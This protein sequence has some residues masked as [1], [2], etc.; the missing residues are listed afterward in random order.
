MLKVTLVKSII[1]GEPRNVK[2]AHALGLRK[3]GQSNIFDDTESIRG[4]IHKIKHLLKVEEVED[5][6]R[7]RRRII[8]GQASAAAAPVAEVEA[9]PKKAKKA[10]KEETE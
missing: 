8:R 1:A 5:Q 7:R 3:I 9:A 4:M 2:T 6:P 10:K